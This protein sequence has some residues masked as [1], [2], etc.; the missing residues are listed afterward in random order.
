[1]NGSLGNPPSAINASR[2]LLGEGVEERYFFAAMLK[3]LQI[4]DVAIESYD[5]KDKLGAYLK[6]L[7]NRSGFA[8]VTTL[9]I[10]RD[11]DDDPK[12]A[13]ASVKGAVARAQF[14]ETVDVRILILP[15]GGQLGALENLCLAPL[16]GS[17]I[18]NC[19]ETYL[20]CATEAT[21]VT[22]TST[23]DKAKARIHA[24]LAA[25][26]SPELRLGH[27]AQKGFLPW[28]SPAFDG[29]KQFL[30]CFN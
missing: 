27:A 30:T 17:R 26:S 18:E 29:L 10:L 25:Q 21:G 22:H 6:A 2:L 8:Q 9:A 28:D 19:I 5:G 1:M 23:T 7:R 15:G 4:A 3:H 24:W 14:P 16:R 20:L 12:A 11:A 13:E